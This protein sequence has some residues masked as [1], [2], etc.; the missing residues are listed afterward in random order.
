MRSDASCKPLD[1]GF[2]NKNQ[3]NNNYKGS[4]D[5]Y[6]SNVEGKD[7]MGEFKK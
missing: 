3:L 4:Q 1:K 5:L 2:F 6:H 7:D